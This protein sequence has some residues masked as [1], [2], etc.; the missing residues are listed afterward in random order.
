MWMQVAFAIGDC[1]SHSRLAIVACQL[2]VAVLFV[3]VVC[4]CPLLLVVC[5]HVLS[6]LG[7][8]L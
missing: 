7:H 2:S 4:V 1:E 8:G 6:S 5:L 3:S